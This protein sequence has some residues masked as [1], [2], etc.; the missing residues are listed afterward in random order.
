MSRQTKKWL[1]LGVAILGLCYFVLH[2]SNKADNSTAT[3]CL[4]CSNMLK[5][6]IFREKLYPR[7]K[8]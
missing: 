4:E 5:I 8:Q 3:N 1:V 7:E 6:K 2:T